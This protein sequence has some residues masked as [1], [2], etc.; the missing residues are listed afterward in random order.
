MVNN[1]G[2]VVAVTV[3]GLTHTQTYDINIYQT[4]NCW[5]HS[6][7]C[8]VVLNTTLCGKLYQ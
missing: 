6:H 1:T 3:V 7:Q 5:V 2:P 4:L 8:R